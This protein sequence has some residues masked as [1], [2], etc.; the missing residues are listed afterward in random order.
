[1]FGMS[2]PTLK[3]LFMKEYGVTATE[4]DK[5]EGIPSCVYM[6]KS[7]FRYNGE[8]LPQDYCKGG[9]A[10]SIYNRMRGQSQSGADV[11]LIWTIEVAS[12]YHADVLESKLQRFAINYNVSKNEA[13]GTELYKLSD[14]ESVALL[15][16]FVDEYNLKDDPTVVRIS[17]YNKD[18]RTSTFEKVENIHNASV[19][20][21]DKPKNNFN[22]L[23]S[24][25]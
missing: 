19:L 25:D 20:N 2:I 1:M 9:K 14:V 18:T 12:L 15:K 22:G 8:Y 6:H 24:F 23:F 5:G 16:Q 7:Y 13:F 4:L 3:T 10:N 11:R 21:R 17:V